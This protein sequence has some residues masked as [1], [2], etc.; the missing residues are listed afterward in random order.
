MR[1]DIL[2]VIVHDGLPMEPEGR[3]H[4]Q[5]KA[6]KPGNAVELYLKAGLDVGMGDDCHSLSPPR[7]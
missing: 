6:R 3:A 4:G 2:N 1:L 5:P 7:E